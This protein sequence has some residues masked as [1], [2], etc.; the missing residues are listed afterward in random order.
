[1]SMLAI[2]SLLNPD[3]S[4]SSVVVPRFRPSPALTSPA[5]SS[6]DE[7]QRPFA[8]RRTPVRQDQRMVVASAATRGPGSHPKMKPKGDINFLPYE[9][10]EDQT[11]RQ[12]L[13]F[14]VNTLGYIRESCQHIPYNSGKK[15][16]FDKTGRESLEGQWGGDRKGI[17]VPCRVPWANQRHRH[18]C[19]VFCY[20]FKVH[21][22]D[23]GYTVRWDYNIGLVRMT[24][25]FKALNYAKV[26]NTGRYRD[27]MAHVSLVFP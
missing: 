20:E 13:G 15:D 7:Q 21:G 9:D 2:S 18:L 23:V 5:T 10:V 19:L 16:F 6:A 12:I 3:P 25:F 8:T 27:V 14:Q 17:A 11:R 26:S 22:S 24:D 4:G 1:M